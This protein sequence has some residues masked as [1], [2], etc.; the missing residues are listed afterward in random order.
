MRRALTCAALLV[1]LAG[2]LVTE[3]RAPLRL[4]PEDAAPRPYSDL[5]RRAEKQVG[6][7]TEAYYSDEW[8]DL[9]DAALALKQTARLLPGAVDTPLRMAKTV[10]GLAAGLSRDAEQLRAGARA[11]DARK[12]H[13]ALQSLHVQLRAFHQ[14]P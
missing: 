6:L 12:V 9:E 8:L 3:E 11:K 4:L 13:S 2:C 1:S 14:S 7:A 5:L 10:P